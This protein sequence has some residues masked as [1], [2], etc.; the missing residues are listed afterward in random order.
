MRTFLNPKQ[1]ILNKMWLLFPSISVVTKAIGG[2]TATS[3]QR[4]ILAVLASL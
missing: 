1:D 3:H 2:Y 4:V